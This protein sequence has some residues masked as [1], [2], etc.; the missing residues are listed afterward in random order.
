M[1]IVNVHDAKTHLSRLLEEVESGEAVI[2]ARHG[3]PIARLVPVHA[4]MRAP[5]VLK[6]KLRIGKDFDA[7]LPQEFLVAFDGRDGDARGGSTSKKPD[8][9]P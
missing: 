7:P 6:G 2:I 1:K 5:G 4:E 9:S 3:T 8:P